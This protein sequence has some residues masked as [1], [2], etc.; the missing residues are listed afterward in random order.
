[1]VCCL[2]PVLAQTCSFIDRMIMSLLVGPVGAAWSIS[3]TQQSFLAGLAFAIFYS[4]MG[5]PLARIADRRSPR[6]IATGISFWSLM[7]AVCGLVQGFWQLF[8]ARLGV[9]IGEATLSPAAYSLIS[10]CFPKGM[11][12]R[13]V[14]VFTLGVTNGSGLASMIRS[15]ISALTQ[16]IGAIRLPMLGEVHGRQATFPFVGAPGLLAALPM[17]AVR[18]PPRQGF[19]PGADS[20]ERLVFYSVLPCLAERRR[21]IALHGIGAVPACRQPPWSGP[22]PDCG[23]VAD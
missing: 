11:L 18:S 13:A 8:V 5:L 16:P 21:A 6:C 3:H 7:T 9:G 20:A 4:I 19:M 10:D 1:M 17:A 23:G 22:W 2:C 12:T 14:S 15:Q